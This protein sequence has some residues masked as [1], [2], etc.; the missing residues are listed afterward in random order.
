M[1]K[2]YRYLV[3]LGLLWV[4]LIGAVFLDLLIIIGAGKAAFSKEFI[5]LYA[6]VD[7]VFLIFGIICYMTEVTYLSKNKMYYKTSFITRATE[8]K[9]ISCV[10]LCQLKIQNARSGDSRVYTNKNE[11]VKVILFFKNIGAGDLGW[12]DTNVD[13]IRAYKQ[14]VCGHAIYDQDLLDQV[15]GNENFNGVIVDRVF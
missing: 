3:D 5:F 12:F 1:R 2:K 9:D 7:S 11:K 15:V 10:V 8:M 6:L 4:A 14:Y 13:L